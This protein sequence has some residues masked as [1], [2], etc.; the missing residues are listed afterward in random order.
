MK[1][2]EDDPLAKRA[3]AE[4]SSMYTVLKSRLAGEAL[5]AEIS[6]RGTD[7]AILVVLLILAP[8][9]IV[10]TFFVIRSIRS[11][12]NRLMEAT[13]T[14]ARGKFNIHL[15][16]TGK[17]EISRLSRAFNEM[18]AELEKAR[19]LEADFLA[20]A[21][22]ELRTPLT[23]ILAYTHK[24]RA[25]LPGTAQ[26]PEA[27]EYLDRIG[28]EVDHLVEKTSD[29]LA[30]GVI[31]AGQLKLR[32]REF[33]T[34]GFLLMTAGSFRPLAVER[35]VEFE[36]EISPHLPTTFVADPDRLEQVLLSLLDNAFKFTPAGGRV[37]FHADLQ[38]GSIQIVVRDTGPGIPAERLDSIF[39]KYSQARTPGPSRGGTG[40]GLAVARGIV[41][42]HGGTIAA[43]SAPGQGSRFVVLLPIGTRSV[44]G[45]E[46]A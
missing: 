3:L 10:S 38:D 44:Q 36:I 31:E 8:L 42:A 19:R 26:N 32:R 21:S 13:E 14:V 43:H 7:R 12:L 16:V 40:L 23:C 41:Q 34:R 27:A 33:M 2:S 17:D 35:G 22:H 11:A 30:F 25:A 18:S 20:I 24:V 45:Q 1:V 5:S 39:E 6:A 15:P 28:K 9:A 4:M 29:L 37:G 46:V